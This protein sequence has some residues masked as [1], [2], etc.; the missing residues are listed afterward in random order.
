MPAGSGQR[1]A[2]QAG[3]GHAER[4]SGCPQA[5]HAS[6]RAARD[7]RGAAEA[8]RRDFRSGLFILVPKP[9]GY[10]QSVEN[11]LSARHGSPSSRGPPVGAQQRGRWDHGA[12][13]PR[14]SPDWSQVEGLT[15]LYRAS[16]HD[17]FVRLDQ[18]APPPRSSER[19]RARTRPGPQRPRTI[20]GAS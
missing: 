16:R 13:R 17:L 10:G 5:A 8:F 1:K 19:H 2:A 4:D 6:S 11:E 12:A 18:P 20:P 9:S 7:V 15:D 14:A 3:T